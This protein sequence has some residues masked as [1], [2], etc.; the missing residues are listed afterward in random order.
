MANNCINCGN[1]ASSDGFEIVSGQ[2]LCGK[3]ARPIRS[4]LSSLRYAKTYEEFAVL[5]R[6]ILNHKSEF[7]LTTNNIV[8]I[9]QFIYFFNLTWFLLFSENNYIFEHISF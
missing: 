2:Y 4:D 3:C 1:K 6:E 7:N 8:F 5:K 9:L